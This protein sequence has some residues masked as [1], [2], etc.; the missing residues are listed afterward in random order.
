[1]IDLTKY[2]TDENE[3]EFLEDIRIAL[4][5][6]SQSEVFLKYKDFPILLEPHGKEFQV[7]SRGKQLGVYETVD[8]M[9]LNFKIAGKLFIEQVQDIE[10]D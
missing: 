4:G 7:W 9:F 3:L 1:M 6:D 2:I 8:D 5:V 10:Y